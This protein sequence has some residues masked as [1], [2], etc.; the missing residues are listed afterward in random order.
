MIT[1]SVPRALM[2]GLKKRDIALLALVIDMAI[3][4]LT[5]LG[6]LLSLMVFL[7]ALSL[8]IGG[9]FAPLI[10]SAV[11]F[12]VYCGAILLS[13]L[14]F[15]RDVLPPNSISSIFP[16]VFNKLTLYRK[17]LYRRGET[18]WVR[19]DRSKGEQ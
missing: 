5:L 11:S 16:Y 6:L 2:E 3:P 10:V 17:I 12:G 9:G 8:L 13:W 14:K 7:S 18:R 1:R 15:G 4:P 19:T